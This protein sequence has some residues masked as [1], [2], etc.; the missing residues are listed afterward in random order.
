MGSTC[1]FEVIKLV[2]A[3][4]LTLV[5]NVYIYIYMVHPPKSPTFWTISR[6]GMIT[7]QLIKG[8]FCSPFLVKQ[9]QIPLVSDNL[10]DGCSCKDL[11]H[12]WTEYMAGSSAAKK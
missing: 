5:Y 10:T 3:F 2:S 9:T 11:V 7:Y 4:L 12:V 8:S 1:A 6:L